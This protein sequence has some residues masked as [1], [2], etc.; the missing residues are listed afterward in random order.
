MVVMHNKVQVNTFK[1][2]HIVDHISHSPLEDDNLCALVSRVHSKLVG[3]LPTNASILNQVVEV[4][5]IDIWMRMEQC[6]YAY[7]ILAP[8]RLIY[9]ALQCRLQFLLNLDVCV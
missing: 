3:L 1:K 2:K 9:P 5:A 7:Y 6:H 8:W 4:K